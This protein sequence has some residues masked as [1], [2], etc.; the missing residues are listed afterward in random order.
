MAYWLV[1]SDPDEYS[2]HD[3]TRDK[4]TLWTGVRNYAARNHLKAM[5][6]GDE[7]LVYHSNDDKAVVGIAKVSKTAVQDPTTTEDAWVAVELQATKLVKNP[8][9]LA[10]MKKEPTLANIGLIKIGRLSVMPVTDEEFARILEMS[11]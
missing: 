7:V 6:K 8:V 9:T 10:A 2:F 11:K 4:K 5:A 1:K 3:L